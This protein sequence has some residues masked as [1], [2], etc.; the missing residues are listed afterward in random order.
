MIG[1]RRLDFGF[2]TEGSRG[3]GF[4]GSRTHI[5]GDLKDLGFLGSN[6]NGVGLD[7]FWGLCI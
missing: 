3:L 5:S 7:F 1:V 6:W 2:G 4:L